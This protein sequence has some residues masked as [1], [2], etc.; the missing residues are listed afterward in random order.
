MVE[1]PH[2]TAAQTALLAAGQEVKWDE[3]GM[4]WTLPDG[5]KKTNS[6][7]NS[8]QAGANGA[9]LIVS[10][11]AMAPDFPTEISL[12]ATHESAKVREK[13]GEVDELKWLELDGVRGVQFRESKPQMADD[14]RRLQW[15]TYRKFANQ[16]QLVNVMLSTSGGKFP[17]RQ[18][19]L[20]AI[21]FST[22]LVH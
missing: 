21:M 15:M 14:I 12:N 18:D 22:K 8:F 17:S 20:Y 4:T 10:I 1:K 6:D 19:E 9:F 2:P 16:T 7:K 3:Q 13:N 5:W 11:S